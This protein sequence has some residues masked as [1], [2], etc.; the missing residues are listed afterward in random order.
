MKYLSRKQVFTYKYY[1][2]GNVHKAVSYVKPATPFNN[3][4]EFLDKTWYL[5]PTLCLGTI[6]VI[7][8]FIRGRKKG[9]EEKQLR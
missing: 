4:K 7:I 9:E 5:W 1:I 2:V 3:G 6:R 8:L